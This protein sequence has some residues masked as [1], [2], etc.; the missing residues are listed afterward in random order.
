M[1]QIEGDAEV[2]GVAISAIPAAGDDRRAGADLSLFGESLAN[3]CEGLG[4]R[5][6]KV[7]YLPPV[8]VDSDGVGVIRVVRL[9]HEDGVGRDADASERLP[10]PMAVKASW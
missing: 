7:P 3:R 2:P 5:S 1:G 8:D 6:W 4:G 10:P 9:G